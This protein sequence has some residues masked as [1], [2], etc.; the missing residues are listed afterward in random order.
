MVNM[1][2]IKLTEKEKEF[3]IAMTKGD[4]ADTLAGEPT[5]YF[6]VP[7]DYSESTKN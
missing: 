6:D 3:L 7:V 2:K 4:Y 1:S 5:Y